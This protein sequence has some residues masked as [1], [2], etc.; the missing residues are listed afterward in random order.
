MAVVLADTGALVA[1]L[2]RSDEW[3]GW[4]VEIF[5]TLSPPLLTCEA[6][7]AEAWHLLGDAGPSRAALIR[8]HRSGIIRMAFDFEMEA[9]SV[10][11]LLEKYADVPMDFAD[12]CLVRMA[13]LHSQSSIWT[14]DADFRVYRRNRRQTIPLIFPSG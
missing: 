1:L 14:M 6:V 7:L 8:L 10:W 3:H 5:K 4:A 13:E 12:A 9:A 2:D 11:R